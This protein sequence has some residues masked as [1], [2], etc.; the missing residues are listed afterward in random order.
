M[1]KFVRLPILTILIFTYFSCSNEEL[2]NNDNLTNEELISQLKRDID[3][4][5]IVSKTTDFSNLLIDNLKSNG[6]NKKYESIN[7]SNLTVAL[8]EIEIIDYYNKYLEDIA[9]HV[10][11]I[12]NK[13]SQLNKL[14][15][16][17]LN[18]IIND[19]LVLK[20]NLPDN[21]YKSNDC[22]AQFQDAMTQIHATYDSTMV[23]CGIAAIV[24]GPVGGAICAGAATVVAIAQTAAAIDAHTICT[25]NQ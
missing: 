21:A 8:S 16:E 22:D 18:L 19:L 3:L 25:H 7:E 15:E 4:I 1:K 12:K 14:S 17:D 2:Q 5:N 6:V 9:Q 10:N 24:G 23:Y 20:R 13:Y 11:N